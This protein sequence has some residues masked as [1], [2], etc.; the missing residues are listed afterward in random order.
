MK[1]PEG[2]DN[3]YI[4]IAAVAAIITTLIG[5]IVVLTGKGKDAINLIES[6]GSFGGINAAGI[7]GRGP[8]YNAR[9]T[10]SFAGGA[11]WVGEEGPELVNLPP[12]THIYNNR[13]S[14][15]IA[16]GNTY[17]INM[18]MDITKLKT[19]N[20]IVEAVTG[21]ANSSGSGGIIHV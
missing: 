5:L 3:T 1:W 16:G 17:Y 13:E 14:N 6:L 10:R 9:G 18:N 4:K 2:L 11:T 21:L 19:V 12:G 20:D 15:Q 8:R 7:T